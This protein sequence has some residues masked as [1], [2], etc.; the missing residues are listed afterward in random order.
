MTEDQRK[1]LQKLIKVLHRISES[2]INVS[3]G[4]LYGSSEFI[5]L[6]GLDQEAIDIFNKVETHETHSKK[7]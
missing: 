3:L 7:T 1:L 2:G 6:L 4:Q 5:V